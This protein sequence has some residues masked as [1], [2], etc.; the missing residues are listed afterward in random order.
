MDSDQEAD[1]RHS[2]LTTGP[3]TVGRYGTNFDHSSTVTW[4]PALIPHLP[5]D[6]YVIIEEMG[7]GG[8]GV[9]FRAIDR[10]LCREV[11]IKLLR[12][13]RAD[14]MESVR[15][16]ET[17]AHIMSF[18]SHPG[19]TPIYDRGHSNDGRP[20]HI[21]RLIEGATLSDLLFQKRLTM[22]RLLVLFA[23]VC[24]TIAYAHSRGI[25]H[26]DLK[27]MNI[28][29]G[30]FGEVNVM[31]WGLSCCRAESPVGPP[32]IQHASATTLPEQQ[33]NPVCGTPAYMSPEQA[34]G[35]PLDARTDVFGLGCILCEILTGGPP[36]PRSS[37]SVAFKNAHSAKLQPAFDRLDQCDGDPILV[38][39]TKHCLQPR[40]KD[41]PANA[42]MLAQ[43]VTDHR[44][45]IVDL[46]RSDMDWYFELSQDLFCITDFDGNF[47]RINDNFS[48]LLGYPQD[49]IL[50]CPHWHFIHEEDRD[51]TISQL[52]VLRQGD[53]VVQFCNRYLTDD[54]HYVTLQ[55]KAK[56]IKEESI[57]AAFARQVS[58]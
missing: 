22:S 32:P 20:F 45:S 19:V 46:D 13:D 38:R 26:L 7:H 9:V 56:S 52:Q 21:M 31:D 14:C 35:G 15:Q 33:G 50:S 23:N 6:R 55:W 42:V 41:R 16:F 34:T 18:L 1:V 3:M 37:A 11:A 43:V 53:P 40:P 8:M 54:G 44:Q 58:S 27:P 2:A 51:D 47:R 36:Y 17:E 5:T 49:K 25:V 28:M 39:L 12:R 24:E 57:I 29:V 30:H 10:H 4:D 48:K